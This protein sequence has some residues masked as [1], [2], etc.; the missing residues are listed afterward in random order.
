MIQKKRKIKKRESFKPMV[1]SAVV[2]FLVSLFIGFMAFSNWRINEKRAGLIKQAE[3]LQKEIDELTKRNEELKNG[4]SQTQSSDYQEEKLYEQGYKKP[5][6]EVVVV[7]PPKEGEK[8]ET[9]KKSFWQKIW[10][11]L[12]F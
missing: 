10:E 2:I 4:I 9:E 12:G 11:R 5:G 6:E 8:G 7:L 3:E 1:A